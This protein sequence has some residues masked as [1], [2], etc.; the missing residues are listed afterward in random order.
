[1]DL[2]DGTPV[3]DIKP[4]VPY[5]DSIASAYNRVAPAEPPAMAVAFS[6]LAS[7]KIG[8]NTQLRS[9][10]EEVLGQDPR[11]QYQAIDPERIFGALIDD[12]NVT[13]RYCQGPESYIEVLD[14]QQR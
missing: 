8:A 12:Y 10:L 9:L 6:E 3:L 7:T 2:V 14:L 1:M 13:W 4:Y 5:A 11:P